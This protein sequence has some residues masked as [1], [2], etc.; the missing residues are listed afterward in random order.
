MIKS[1]LAYDIE[2][3]VG[4]DEYNDWLVDVHMPDLL[5]NPFVDKLLFDTVLHPITATSGNASAIVNTLV[6]YRIAEIHFADMAAYE[7]AR[8]W[9]AEHPIPPERGPAGRTRFHFYVLTDVL[10]V[11]REDLGS[12]DRSVLFAPGGAR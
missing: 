3:G 2:D 8:A 12:V 5:A 1:V 10:E 9:F 11:G 4:E 6:P 7:N